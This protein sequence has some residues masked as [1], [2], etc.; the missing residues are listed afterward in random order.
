MRGH[1]ADNW[2]DRLRVYRG[3]RMELGSGLFASDIDQV[4]WRSV[5]G[6]LVPVALLEVTRVSVKEEL[7]DFRYWQEY[8]AKIIERYQGTEG[9]AQGEMAQRLSEMLRV[10]VYIVAHWPDLSRFWVCCWWDPIGQRRTAW[11]PMTLA[12]YLSFLRRMQ[13]QDVDRYSATRWL[14]PQREM[15]F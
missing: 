4:E 13:P 5:D 2:E 3:W 7:R 9:G 1:R 8:L 14:Q 12:E 11:Y 6:E 15:P 10:P